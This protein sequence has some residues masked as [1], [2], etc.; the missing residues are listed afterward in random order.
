MADRIPSVSHVSTASA[1][2]STRAGA[3]AAY[4]SGRAITPAERPAVDFGRHNLLGI[5]RGW[6]NNGCWGLNITRVLET[7]TQI[8]VEYLQSKGPARPDTLCSQALVPMADFVTV[9]KSD[10]PVLY[11]EVT[12]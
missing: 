6:G 9:P 7:A 2:R 8:R 10:K 1:A 11:V 12:P 5:S 3:W 4:T